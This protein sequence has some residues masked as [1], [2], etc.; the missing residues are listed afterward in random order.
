MLETAKI[1]PFA[2]DLGLRIFE[3]PACGAATSR[4]EPAPPARRRTVDSK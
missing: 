1:A 4:L 2:S 3:C